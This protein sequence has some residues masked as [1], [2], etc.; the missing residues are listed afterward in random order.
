ML[1]DLGDE[2]SRLDDWVKLPKKN[3][4]SSTFL[5]DFVLGSRNL[6]GS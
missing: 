5:Q 2:K 3:H 6:E 4:T 1:V